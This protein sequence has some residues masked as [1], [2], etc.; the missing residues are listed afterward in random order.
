DMGIHAFTIDS[1]NADVLER[2]PSE[3]IVERNLEELFK[4]AEGRIIIA[5]F[6]SVITRIA[7]V[8]KIA[9]RLG[10]KV[11][12][13]GYSMKAN[14]QIAQNLGFIKAKEGTLVPAEEIH[15]Y[16]DNK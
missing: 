16:R 8:I 1:T 9:E 14:I 11:V 7:E 5:M 3:R 15:K 6:A 10:K 2:S 13:S 4:K 12:P